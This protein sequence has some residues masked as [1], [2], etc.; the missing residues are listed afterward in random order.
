MQHSISDSTMTYLAY[1]SIVIIVNGFNA[2][3]D[4][5]RFRSLSAQYLV[6]FSYVTFHAVLVAQVS[7]IIYGNFFLLQHKSTVIFALLS[8][9]LVFLLSGC[10][11]HVVSETSASIFIRRANTTASVRTPRVHTLT[12]C[13][14]RLSLPQL[15]SSQA[16]LHR[17]EVIFT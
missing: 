7:K 3:R 10:F 4:N 12:S 5:A 9:T 14:A 11:Q 15:S 6:L 2:K 1:F 13:P 8:L 17:L 16:T